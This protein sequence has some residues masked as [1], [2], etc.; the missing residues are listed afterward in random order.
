M[1]T[2]ASP[3]QVALIKG[4]L[5]SLQRAVEAAEEGDPMVAAVEAILGTQETGLAQVL[6][7]LE[8]DKRTASSIIDA[9]FAAEK[10]LPPP[11]VRWVKEGD[12]F[13]IKGAAVKLVPGEVVTTKTRNGDKPAIVG[14]VVRVEGPIAFATTRP[15]PEGERQTGLDLNA[16]FEGLTT[17]AGDPVTTIYVADPEGTEDDRLKLQIDRPRAGRW[18]G[19]IFVKDA[20][21][22]GHGR[23]YGSQRPGSTS[24]NGSVADVL[25]RV[26]ADRR[27]AMARYGQ[28]VGVCG[29]CGRKLEDA[30]SVA[31]G[32]GPWCA[33]QV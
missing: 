4:K 6:G 10:L 12:T 1:S 11:D 24:Y 15:M 3:K 14:E 19:W 16:L 2:T 22:Y 17:Q 21:E 20:A 8:V 13:L 5:D 31:L 29:R 30:N 28:L 23:K 9:L 26:L 27:T 32:L 33:T 25:G 7:G 18:E